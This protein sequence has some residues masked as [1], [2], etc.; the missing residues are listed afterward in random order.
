MTAG[1]DLLAPP[2]ASETGAAGPRIRSV[3]GWRETF[4]ST[5]GKVVVFAAFWCVVALILR[6]AR[7]VDAVTMVLGYFGLPVGASLFSLVLLALIGGA[8]RRRLRI[9]LWVLL[10]ME[11][12]S[13]LTSPCC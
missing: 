5:T 6:R 7:P 12:L 8:V 4:A 13:L 10:V 9:G 1:N 11:A 3:G 2:I